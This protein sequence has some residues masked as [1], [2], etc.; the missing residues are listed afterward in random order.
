VL[1]PF[2]LDVEWSNANFNAALALAL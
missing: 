2:L 1:R